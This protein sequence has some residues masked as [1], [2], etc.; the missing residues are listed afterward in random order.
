M[1]LERVLSLFLL[2]FCGLYG[3][4]AFDYPLLPFERNMAF[5]PNT[6]PKALSIAGLILSFLVLVTR[7]Q[8]QP[9]HDF[10]LSYLKEAAFIV[11]AMV[12]YALLLRPIG[13]IPATLIFLIGCG[14][15]LGEKNVMRLGLI[16]SIGTVG[17]WFLVQEILGIFLR[18]LPLF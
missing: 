13:F 7:T 6:L 15:I 5:L 3:L 16:A 1:T 10:A 18:P 17:I 9:V 12:L 14:R 8:Q 11:G 4:A 2:L